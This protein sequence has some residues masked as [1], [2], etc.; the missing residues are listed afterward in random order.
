MTSDEDDLPE[1]T[2][3]AAVRRAC[4]VFLRSRDNRYAARQDE[5]RVRMV[6][7]HA[8]RKAEKEKTNETNEDDN[9]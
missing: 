3:M 1:I 7:S 2:N 4:D 8:R 6:K 9:G 5:H